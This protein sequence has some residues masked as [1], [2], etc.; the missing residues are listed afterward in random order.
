MKL[1]HL[2]EDKTDDLLDQL[3]S[4]R[5]YIGEHNLKVELELI[6]DK[7]I[8]QD[9]TGKRMEIDDAVLEALL[10][11]GFAFDYAVLN[12]RFEL[13][14]PEIAKDCKWSYHYARIINR[15]FE[16]GEPEIAKDAYYAYYYAL[17][18]IEGRF[19]QGEPVIAKNAAYA[20]FYAHDVIKGRFELGE[21]AIMADAEY[22]SSYKKFLKDK[23]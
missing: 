1:S 23:Q 18:V 20:C 11:P 17:N 3:M 4:L 13:G 8:L 15:R 7:L 22:R 12:G 5:N 6:G 9:S 19:E 14:E 2:L 10:S 21:K 16:L